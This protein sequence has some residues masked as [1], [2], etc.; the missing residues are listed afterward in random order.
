MMISFYKAACKYALVFFLGLTVISCGKDDDKVEPEKPDYGNFYK[1]ISVRNFQ[2]DTTDS[3]PTAPK[4]TLYYSLENNERVAESY[5]KTTRW[6]L[7]FGALYSSALA[8]NNGADQTNYGSGSS[9]TGGILI[10]AQAFDDVV[11][12]PSDDQFKTGKDLFMT[13]NAGDFGT[14]TGWYIYDFGGTKVGDGSYDKQHVVYALGDGVTMADKTQ[15]APRTL[16]V[17]TANG[18]YAKIKMISVYKDALTIDKWTRNA[19][20]MYFNFDYLMVPKGST[21]FETK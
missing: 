12:I 16:V 4:V 2:G 20:H 10:L 17:R 18:N 13:D 14:G 8:G 7:S 21:K 15:I 9:A 3:N 11:D 6:D 1:T 5:Q 19:P